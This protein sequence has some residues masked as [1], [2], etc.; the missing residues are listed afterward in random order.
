MLLYTNFY[1]QQKEK[2][3]QLDLER[4]DVVRLE[5]NSKGCSRSVATKISQKGPEFRVLMTRKNC[6]QLRGVSG[7]LVQSL[8]T[9][10]KGWLPLAHIQLSDS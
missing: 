3:L 2:K 8:S 1:S 10:W 6:Q 5:E 7:V 4:G 9:Q